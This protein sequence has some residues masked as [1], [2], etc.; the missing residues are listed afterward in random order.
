[1]EVRAD[2][3]G[4]NSAYSTAVTATT[5]LATPSSVTLSPTSTTIV[6]DWADVSGATGYTVRHQESGDA[7]TET[8][9]TTTASEYTMTSLSVNT[10]YSVEVRADVTGGNS[11][12]STAVTATTLL[13]TPSSVTLSPTSTT[14][15]VDWA[16]VSGA[17]GYTVRHQ[18]SGD[19][20]TETTATTTASE[21]TIT[22][23]SV[24]TEYS[25]EV[26]ADVTGGN[27]A[28]STAVTATTLLGALGTVSGVTL[29]ANENG[30]MDVV[31]DALSNAA[32][33]RIQWS[34][35]S[36]TYTSSNEATVASAT[37]AISGLDGNVLY[38][39]QVRGEA[40][41]YDDGP[42]ST[43]DS[44]TTALGIPT[45]VQ[46]TTTSDSIT[47]T[48]DAV[49]GAT[50]YI[51]RH[52][53]DGDSSTLMDVTLGSVTTH[54]ISSLSVSTKYNVRIRATVGSVNSQWSGWEDVTTDTVAL[55]GEPT[56][57]TLTA[58]FEQL[59]ASWVVPALVGGSS[60]TDYVL[61]YRVVG[62]TEWEQVS[63][64]SADTSYDITSLVA[65]SQ[66]E[67]HVAAVN[68]HGTGG[69][70]T[71]PVLAVA[72]GAPS[73]PAPANGLVSISA[74]AAAVDSMEI[75]WSA[76][77]DNG[78]II[79]GYDLRYRLIETTTWTD[80]NQT[81]TSYTA[82]GLT[83]Q[84]DYEIQVRATNIH[85]SSEYSEIHIA[86]FAP[87]I[88]YIVDDNARGC[89]IGTRTRL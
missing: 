54:T 19:S 17:T 66:Y 48:W 84:S 88:L 28:Y 82:S 15:V 73:T 9:V 68:S 1:M 6:V 24:N 16:D 25:V 44:E 33:Y 86:R 39:V 35:T 75:Y 10:E 30:N 89:I 55:P 14:I 41:Q 32:T 3:T 61:E 26:R 47:V 12:Y 62:A 52:R 81:G 34:T 42:Y 23:L 60:I 79:T 56:A 13:S 20:T 38:Y 63:V 8:T 11:A 18:E 65:G 76:P 77:S 27:S 45:N 4:A 2:V 53:E 5:L 80:V 46:F 74:D 87:H 36:G 71:P 85:G 57:L 51:I 69:F 78:S 37:H 7:S 67:V 64:G 31:W 70:S 22:S 40:T 58:G 83:L 49:S 72:E 59:A 43:E 29:T 50:G 21:Y